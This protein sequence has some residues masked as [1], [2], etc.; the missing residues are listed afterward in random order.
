M[1]IDMEKF[2]PTDA[3]AAMSAAEAYNI[4]HDAVRA[5]LLTGTHTVPD[6]FVSFPIYAANKLAGVVNLE[7][8]GPTGAPS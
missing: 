8:I 5:F 7:P 3:N 2:D 1:K 6:T 4:L